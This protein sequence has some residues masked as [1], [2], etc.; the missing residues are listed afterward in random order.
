VKRAM[1]TAQK[2]EYDR[3]YYAANRD[4]T[5]AYY[6]ANRDKIQE[7]N[8]QRRADP[9]KRE[10]DLKRMRERNYANRRADPRIRLLSC[11][12]A[13]AVEHGVPFDLTLHDIAIPNFCP[14]L[15]ILL[16]PGKGKVGPNSPTLDRITPELGYVRGNVAV[17][18]HK[19]NAIKNNATPLELHAVA[20]WLGDIALFGL[21]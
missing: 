7:R 18:S 3:A 8:R 20:H 15:G 14:A 13:R 9:T 12:K 6:A 19:A 4:K 10:H 2:R 5:R 21:G 11:A 1:R 16:T 17:I